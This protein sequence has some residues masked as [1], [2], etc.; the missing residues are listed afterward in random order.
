MQNT[1]TEI[2]TKKVNI[3][4]RA[5]HQGFYSVTVEI[6]WICP[7]C[8]GPRGEVFDTVSFDGSLR[9]YCHGWRNDCGHVDGYGDVR[10]EAAARLQ[11]SE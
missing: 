10:R 11:R 1:K 7:V 9:L 2:E 8:G 4:A 5:E 6:D 3:P